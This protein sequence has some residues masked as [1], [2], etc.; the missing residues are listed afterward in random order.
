MASDGTVAARL[1]VEVGAKG[2][3]ETSAGLGMMGAAVDR[4]S[5]GLKQLA[6]AAGGIYAVKKGFDA[7]IGS[8]IAWESEFAGVE[9]TVEGTD[10]E[11]A[12]LEDTLLGMHR[13]MPVA[14]A[15]L[16]GIAEAAGAL[17][18]KTGAIDEFTETV[19]M[20]GETTNVSSDMA[21]S[22]LGKLS[23]VL[24]LTV[25]DYDNFGA[26]LVDLGNKGASTEQE[27]LAIAERAGAG[28]SLIDIAADATLGWSAAVANLGIEAEAGGSAL[29]RIFLGA[30]EHVGKAG[31]EL[32]AMAR[33]AGM[34]ASEFA[35]AFD[36]DASGALERF[37]AG[38]GVMSQTQQIAMLDLLGFGDIRISRTILGLAGNVDNLSDSLEIGAEGWADNTALTEEYGK[39]VETVASQIEMLGNRFGDLGRRIGESQGGP[40]DLFLGLSDASLTGWERAFASLELEFGEG[41]KRV[42]EIAIE[43]GRHFRDVIS[44]AENMAVELGIGVP[45]ALELVARDFA[46]LP[47][48][49]EGSMTQVHNAVA[50]NMGGVVTSITQGVADSAE[51]AGELPGMM[52]D[53]LLANQFLLTDATTQLVNFMDEALSP[54]QEKAEA[55]A[56]LASDALAMALGSDNPLVRQKA[57]ELAQ[58]AIDVLNLT[59]DFYEGGRRMGLAWSAGL[60][61]AYGASYSAGIA[62]ASG[63]GLSLRGLSPPK[64][65]PLQNIDTDAMHIGMAWGDGLG[66]AAGYIEDKAA[67][68]AGIAGSALSGIGGLS[69]GPT[70]DAA[71]AGNAASGGGVTEVNIYLTVEGDLKADEQTLPGTLRRAVFASGLA[72]QQR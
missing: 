37:I 19:A 35:R 16:A 57:A 71:A 5:G 29:Q 54:M 20:I 15:D 4:S 50:E 49:V 42:Q 45:E 26:A 69:G 32:A 17:G 55:Q 61:S 24:G 33:T 18:I 66:M 52:A 44:E 67:G 31:D 63:A 41:N 28:A 43:T 40:V 34:S 47:S 23:N 21:A 56:F 13:T 12:G 9:K 64:E 2:L 7:T 25:D 53:E 11:L 51:M 27:I 22:A 38:L 46:G 3:N 59:D 14:R 60:R 72:E 58:Q 68:L 1:F 6:I 10:A 65:G 39:R 36:E 8:A 70:F 30:A 62:L 48:I